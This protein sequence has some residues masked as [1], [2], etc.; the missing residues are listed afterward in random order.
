MKFR[1]LTNWAEVSECGRY[2]VSAA[3]VEGCWSFTAWR[4]GPYVGVVPTLLGS[5][6]IS[7][8]AREL[9]RRHAKSEKIAA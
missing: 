1:R 5:H 8:E 7:E 9:C 4:R 6:R 3:K 2:T